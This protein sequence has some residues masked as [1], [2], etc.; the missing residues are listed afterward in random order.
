MYILGRSIIVDTVPLTICIV[1][2]I[3]IIIDIGAVFVALTQAHYNSNVNS[4]YY[5]SNNICTETGC[6]ANNG[7]YNA[8]ARKFGSI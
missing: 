8:N 2:L 4:N 7:Q 1:A 5:P 6:T 3:A